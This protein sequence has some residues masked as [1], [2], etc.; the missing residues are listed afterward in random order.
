MAER[1]P[2]TR[3]GLKKMEEKLS[4][5]Q[6]VVRPQVEKRLGEAREMGDLSEN[7]EF[8]SAREEIWRLD[9]E[10]GDL[11]HRIQ[12]AEIVTPGKVNRSEVAFGATVRL[13]DVKTNE[14]D[15]YT[16]VGEGE[17]APSEGRIAITTPIG[18]AL[19]GHKIGDKVDIPIPAGT[20]RYEILQIDYSS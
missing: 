12:L 9:A 2:M 19:L 10:V 16:F 5:L 3:E 8:D 11:Q 1:I 7:A 4:H 13:K 17:S 18:Q 15:E 20:L 14:I 6:N